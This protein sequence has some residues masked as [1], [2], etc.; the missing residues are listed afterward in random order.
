MISCAQ[1]LNI[2]RVC[3][4]S[5]F[6]FRSGP[7]DVDPRRKRRNAVQPEPER[8]EISDALAGWYRSASELSSGGREPAMRLESVSSTC[9]KGAKLIDSRR[10]WPLNAPSGDVGC[11]SG[12]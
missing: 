10:S 12:L 9:R 4:S 2:R 6:S 8:S 7:A 5:A 11:A 3:S 1:A